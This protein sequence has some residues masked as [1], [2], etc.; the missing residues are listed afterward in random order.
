MNTNQ[1]L[2][3]NENT[4]LIKN[5]SFIATIEANDIIISPVKNKIN[6]LN[7]TKKTSIIKYLKEN[8]IDTKQNLDNIKSLISRVSKILKTSYFLKL[9]TSSKVIEIKFN[10]TYKSTFTGYIREYF[11]EK[12]NIYDT[13]TKLY[14]YYKFEK[15]I[16]NIDF[17][18]KYS[19]IL[20]TI[21]NIKKIKLIH[22]NTT[23]SFINYLFSSKISKNE[24]HF[25]TYRINIE[26]YML[27]FENKE[28]FFVEDQLDNL[29]KSTNNIT[30]MNK[31]YS[32]HLKYGVLHTK[33]NTIYSL[34]TILKLTTYMM[35]K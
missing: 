11:D 6:G 5:H 19:F 3:F 12:N 2:I 22:P 25:K 8:K 20:L 16:S 13:L 1:L 9:K 29:I 31:K 34:H 18:N 14:N 15:D 21:S 10:K 32:L 28:I 23:S 17:K 30:Y 33:K 35:N 27:V 24:N 4:E 26:E 7:I